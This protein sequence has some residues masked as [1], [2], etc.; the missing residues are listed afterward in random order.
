MVLSAASGELPAG[1]SASIAVTLNREGI[2]EGDLAETI[3]ITHAAGEESVPVT[4]SHEDNPIIHNPQASPSTV[5]V[6]GCSGSTTTISARVRDTSELERVFVRWSPDGSATTETE[7]S[8]AGNDIYQ[9]TIGPFSAPQSASMRVIAFDVRGNA[10][11][12]RVS[13]TV[14]A[15]S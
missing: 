11:G 14:N 2:S 10:G 4:G 9:G 15:C 12:A 7:L 13:V 5:T 6:A 1:E 3:T 8:L